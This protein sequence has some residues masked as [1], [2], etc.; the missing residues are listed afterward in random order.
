MQ[1][2]GR[3]SGAEGRKALRAEGRMALLCRGEEGSPCRGE[4][5]APV[6]HRGHVLPVTSGRAGAREL[7][8]ALAPRCEMFP[9]LSLDLILFHFEE[10]HLE[11]G[12][13]CSVAVVLVLSSS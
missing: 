1:R 5:G 8:A 6:Q 11:T 13:P 3:H 4:E 2:G 10:G 12:C 7:P 9:F